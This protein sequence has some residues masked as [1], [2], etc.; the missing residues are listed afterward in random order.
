MRTKTFP[1]FL[2]RIVPVFTAIILLFAFLLTGC[3]DAGDTFDGNDDDDD[4]ITVV[5]EGDV[6]TDMDVFVMPAKLDYAYGETFSPAGLM[7]AASYENGYDADLNLTADALDGWAPTGPLDSSVKFVILKYK[8]FEYECPVTVSDKKLV[9]FA[10]TSL[11]L[12]KAYNIGDK[13]DLDGLN[14]RTTYDYGVVENETGYVLKDENGRVFK[15]GMVLDYAELDLKLTASM[16]SG[17]V[18]KSDSFTIDVFAGMT[19]QAEK[20]AKGVLPIDE[21]YTLI[22]GGEIRTDGAFSGTGYVGGMKAGDILEFD[23]FSP[24]KLAE[25]D[26][27]I[28]AASAVDGDGGTSDVVFNDIFELYVDGIK[29]GYDDEIV[30]KGNTFAQSDS[31]LGKTDWSALSLGFIDI[32][33]GYTKISLRCLSGNGS[34]NIDRLYIQTYTLADFSVTYLSDY[35]EYTPGSSFSTRGLT[36]KAVYDMG[37]YFSDDVTIGEGYVI[38]DADGNVYADGTIL[39]GL[40]KKML[41]VSYEYRGVYKS[42]IFF[43]NIV[44]GIHVSATDAAETGN[45][46]SDKSYTKLSG[47]YTV[48]TGMDCLDNIG[49]GATI[50]FHIYSQKA[51]DGADLIVSAAPTVEK[52]GRMQSMQF[53]GMFGVYDGENASRSDYFVGDGVKIEGKD[54]N[55]GADGK[56]MWANTVLGK[57]DIVPGFNVITLECIG[58]IGGHTAN[59][60]GIDIRAG[61][62]PDV[63]DKMLESVEIVN[64]PT[65]VYYGPDSSF[66]TTGLS[67]KAVYSDTVVENAVNYTIENG[68]G[69]HYV[70][71]L[72]LGKDRTETELTVKITVNGI[73]KSDTFVIHVNTGKIT[74]EFEAFV[75]GDNTPANASYTKRSTTSIQ[76]ESSANASGG[77]SI[78]QMKPGY[79]VDIYVY[80]ETAVKSATFTMTASTNDRHDNG[81]Y[82]VD[83]N[84]L[85]KLWANDVLIDTAGAIIKGRDKTGSE[86]TYFCWTESV[87]GKVDLNAG[88]TRIRLDIFGEVI[89]HNNGT[90]VCC[91]LDKVDLYV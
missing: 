23:V 58:D 34:V 62:S 60:R 64:A 41:T 3:A 20:L 11:P 16:T 75:D 25:A 65:Y 77:K 59:I 50:E 53:N 89:P 67:V 21:S 28:M 90:P 87:I 70:E 14:L 61:G 88:F 81:T 91:N 2:S 37:G 44:D 8:G 66:D 38:K 46:P 13:L 45:E 22:K 31:A 84:A 33:K 69:L 24:K 29:V 42:D 35:A 30:L 12:V 80:S 1:V 68:D 27:T 6:C 76:V 4:D 32:N 83:F 72:S 82:D 36:A 10:I 9:D 86:S 7:F 47:D 85:Y 63:R 57:I 71:G 79:Y 40:G 19:V 74:V 15:D 52:N 55:D 43:I 51:Y 17:G 56:Y 18:T 73:T 48:N 49:K 5:T 39:T 26:V 78:C 54:V